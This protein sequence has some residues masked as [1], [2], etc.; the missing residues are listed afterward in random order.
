MST[1]QSAPGLVPGAV[2]GPQ[3][4]PAPDTGPAIFLSLFG[5]RDNLGDSVLRRP[6]YES[7]R[8]LGPIHAAVGD[9]GDDYLAA[10]PL[11]SRTTLYASNLKWAA[12]ALW[13]AA[14]RRT[15][16]AFVAGEVVTTPKSALVYALYGL[17]ARAAR[18]RAGHAVFAGVGV[19]I[20]SRPW[21]VRV[22]RWMIAPCEIVVTRDPASAALLQVPTVGPDWAFLDGRPT[23]TD[24]TMGWADR[25][26][27]AVSL[28]GDQPAPA[29]DTVTALGRAAKLA[30]LDVVVVSQVRRDNDRCRD[31]ARQFGQEV[32][33]TVVTWDTGNHPEHE[34]LVREVYRRSAV[35]VGDR[36]HALIVAMT[37][38]AVPL[39]LG[40]E[41]SRK[42]ENALRAVGYEFPGGG[43]G[44]ALPGG[45]DAVAD[46]L[47]AA[48][49]SGV[50]SWSCVVRARE[51]L[52]ATRRRIRTLLADRV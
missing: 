26:S 6:W 24:P 32:D 19:K 9:H 45:G 52:M 23:G 28:R 33:A 10:F 27:L 7:F 2:A 46:V 30:G 20:N 11:D 49:G 5:Q 3:T 35:V 18:I 14:R 37:E 40:S 50:A 17:I 31:L 39:P 21:V 34:V 22:L 12:A 1:P 44:P 43:L 42:A 29:A 13:S 16:M 15:V 25:R 4:D 8:G 38:G 47:R 41:F 36:L 48:E 51:Q